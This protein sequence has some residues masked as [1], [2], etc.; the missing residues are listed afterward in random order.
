MY[1]P[2][3]SVNHCK[4]LKITDQRLTQ[5]RAT[6]LCTPKRI[7]LRGWPE[8]KSDCRVEIRQIKS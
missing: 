3:E 5:V 6:T 4:N 7:V 8:M 1:K 2:F